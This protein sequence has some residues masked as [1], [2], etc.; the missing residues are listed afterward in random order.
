[1]TTGHAHG[2]SKPSTGAH[3]YAGPGTFFLS[4]TNY[5]TRFQSYGH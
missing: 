2:L 5:Q 4:A 3:G 1:M